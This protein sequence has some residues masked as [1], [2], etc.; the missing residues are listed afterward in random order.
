MKSKIQGGLML[1]EQVGNIRTRHVSNMGL[2]SRPFDNWFKLG[3]IH[4]IFEFLLF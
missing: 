4:V 1:R 3:H 2:T